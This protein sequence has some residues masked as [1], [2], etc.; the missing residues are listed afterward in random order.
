LKRFHQIDL[1]GVVTPGVKPMANAAYQAS[2]ALRDVEGK[3]VLD[4]GA[5]DGYFSFAA[6]QRGA[7]RVLATDHFCW[8]GPGWG[9]IDGFLV[10]KNIL[11]STVEHKV[12]D[13]IEVSRDTVGV[14]DV[15]LFLGVLYHLKEPFTA[16]ERISSCAKERIVVE[17]ETAF[18]DLPFPAARFFPGGELNND[19]SNWWAPNRKAIE[20]M[21]KLFGFKRIEW[22]ALP[23]VPQ[24]SE[25]GRGIFVA[26]RS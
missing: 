1:G 7:T 4:V 21:L 18:D 11:K 9:K 6:E 10:A 20:G 13:A 26:Y 12:I 8:V 16:L 19:P 3:T 15:V 25:R 14:F 24:S 22:T 17:T 23:W 2:V 5:W